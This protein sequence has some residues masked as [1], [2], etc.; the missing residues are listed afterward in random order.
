MVVST[1][2]T[3]VSVKQL[4]SNTDLVNLV[5]MANQIQIGSECVISCV[6]LG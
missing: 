1:V 4:I 2:T 3:E 6:F 5:K